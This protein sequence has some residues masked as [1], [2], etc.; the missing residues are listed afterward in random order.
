MH[1]NCWN[2]VDEP[3]PDGEDDEQNFVANKLVDKAK[4][5]NATRQLVDVMEWSSLMED[6]ISIRE[7]EEIVHTVM[8]GRLS[9]AVGRSCRNLVGKRAQHESAG[10]SR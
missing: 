8:N 6:M 7:A 3:L 5:G 9:R 10:P 1:N 4:L 2:D